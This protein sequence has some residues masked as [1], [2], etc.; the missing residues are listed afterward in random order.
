MM[1]TIVIEYNDDDD[2]RV[3]GNDAWLTYS[4]QLFGS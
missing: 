2:D 1:K 3:E 4:S